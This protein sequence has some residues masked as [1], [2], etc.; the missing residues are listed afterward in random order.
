MNHSFLKIILFAALLAV[1][2]ILSAQTQLSLGQVIE[3]ALEHDPRIDEKE[4]FVR[5]AQGLLAEAEG[6]GG[7]RYSVDTYLALGTDVE[8]G[9]YDDGEVSCSSNCEPRDDIYNFDDGFSLWAGLTFSV[10]KPLMTFGRLE[11][12]QNAA[13]HN[14]LVKQQDVELQRDA[15][16]LDVVRAY[17]GY[18]TARDSRL[19]LE[20]TRKRLEAALELVDEWLEEGKGTVSQSDKYA[21]ESGMGLIDSYLAEASG[22]EIIAMAGLKVLTG[23]KADNIQLEDKRLNPVVLPTRSLQE[24]TQLAVKN[25]AEFKQVEA[26][27]AARRALVEASRSESKPIVF[28]G[29]AGTMAYAPGR[30]TLDNPHIYDPFNHVAMS[31]LLGMRWEWEQGAQPARVAQ[32]QAELDALIHTASFARNGVPFQVQEQYVWVHSKYKSTQSMRAS[33]RA[34]RRWMISA[35]ADFEAGLEEAN[36][37][38]TAM[39]VY[40]LAYAEYL[41]TVNDY[42]NHVFKLQSVSGVFE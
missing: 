12:Y 41:K 2:Q 13:R 34:G 4:A 7:L 30:D 19:L 32:A 26:G 25:R 23:L 24:W 8:G 5:Q 3:L 37:I 14:I 22:L 28:A 1:S 10:I 16:R 33:A 11:S 17:Y 15:I 35:Y 18:L 38:L 20:D 39:Q 31:P 36:K 6:S 42:N 29:L 40:V 21:L 27:L 9:F